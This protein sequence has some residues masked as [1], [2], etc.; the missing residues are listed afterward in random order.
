MKKCK[1]EL[2][3][4][5]DPVVD[6]SVSVLGGGGY[7]YPPIFQ[8]VKCLRVFRTGWDECELYEIPIKTIED[9]EKEEKEYPTIKRRKFFRKPV[10]G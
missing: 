8:C 3:K 6:V 5:S 1:H 10:N 4:L 7:Q 2:K 9:L